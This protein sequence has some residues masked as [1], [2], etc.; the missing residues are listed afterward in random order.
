MHRYVA[1]MA[2]RTQIPVTRS[3]PMYA[4]CTEA[5]ATESSITPVHRGESINF[6]WQVDSTD[7]ARAHL[8]RPFVLLLSAVS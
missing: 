3:A 5:A 7:Q 4:A 8:R 1:A 2:E 6:E